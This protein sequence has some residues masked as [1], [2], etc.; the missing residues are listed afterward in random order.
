MGARAVEQPVWLVNPLPDSAL[1]TVAS[2]SPRSSRARTTALIN[3]RAAAS[4]AGS[5]PKTLGISSFDATLDDLLRFVGHGLSSQDAL[6][7]HGSRG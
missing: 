7:G 4:A 5:F 6:T 2:S 3:A 1:A